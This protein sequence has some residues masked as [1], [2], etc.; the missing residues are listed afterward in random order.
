[1]FEVKQKVW[2]TVFGPGEVVR[3]LTGTQFCVVVRFGVDGFREYF[4]LDGKHQSSAMQTLFPYPVQ[5]V[6]KDEKPS[7]DWDHVDPKYEYLARDSFGYG[8]LY[9][10]KPVPDEK[11]WGV[12]EGKYALLADDYASYVPGTCDWW[13][14]LVKRP[15]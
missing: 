14:S 13:D 6:K 5:V 15:D 9:S 11:I 2:D 4:T 1:M 7:I 12:P 8:W 3:F 10:E